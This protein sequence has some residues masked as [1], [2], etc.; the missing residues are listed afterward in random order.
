M[1]CLYIYIWC[2][3]GVFIIGF[4]NFIVSF[5][6][7]LFLAMRSRSIPFREFILVNQAIFARF[8]KHPQTFFFPPKNAKKEFL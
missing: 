5:S 2:L 4:F 7:S 8:K 6:L 3:L 1:P